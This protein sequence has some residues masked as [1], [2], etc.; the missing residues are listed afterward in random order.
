MEVICGPQLQ[1]FENRLELNKLRAAQL[2]KEKEDLEKELDSIQKPHMIMGWWLCVHSKLGQTHFGV[3]PYYIMYAVSATV[4][5]VDEFLL[6]ARTQH[7]SIAR[8]DGS[9]FIQTSHGFL[10]ASLIGQRTI[11]GFAYCQ[12]RNGFYCTLFLF[13]RDICRM[14]KLN[15][16]VWW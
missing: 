15:G 9:S 12:L 10:R 5:V 16:M 4:M 13:C 2:Q 8:G 14:M 11:S 1:S 3:A 6:P 7:I